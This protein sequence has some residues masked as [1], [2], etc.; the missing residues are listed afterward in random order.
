MAFFEWDTLN[1]SVK[2]DRRVDWRIDI[3]CGL[4]VL[5]GCRRRCFYL[6]ASIITSVL[7]MFW[8][9]IPFYGVIMLWLS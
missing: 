2:P 8:V 4:I 9:V 6:S 7:P 1:Y 5:I 3:H